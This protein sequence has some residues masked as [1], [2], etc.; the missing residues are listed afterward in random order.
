LSPV[1]RSA[2]TT[3]APAFFRAQHRTIRGPRIDHDDLVE[4]GLVEQQ[5]AAKLRDHA[6]D[7]LLLVERGN[8]EADAKPL[9]VLF[10]DQLVRTREIRRVERAVLEPFEDV[11]VFSHQS[12]LYNPNRPKPIKQ[13]FPEPKK[14]V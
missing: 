3:V 6:R 11:D 2:S 7:G 14:A 4:Q 12:P 9:R 5:F 8:A 1:T 10:L 13:R